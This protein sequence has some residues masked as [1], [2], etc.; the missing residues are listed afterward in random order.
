MK[1]LSNYL[2]VQTVKLDLDSKDKNQLLK[3]LYE[4]FSNA[5][6]ITDKKKCFED[7]LERE[8]LGS[9]GI[10]KGVAIPHAK[11]QGVKD[12]IM[13]VGVCK[14]E[15]S[16]DSIDASPVNIVFM[17]LSPVE[18]SQE[19]LI[20]LARISRLIKED[21]FR[22]QILNAKTNEEIFDILDSKEV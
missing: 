15:I 10:G 7:I 13:T 19:Y 9:T 16:Y 11:T 21:S 1:K 2:K 8:K 6:E 14:N 20:M 18:M 12:I 17:F 5:P 3:D 22:N 4:S